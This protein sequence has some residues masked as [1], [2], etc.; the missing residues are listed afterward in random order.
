MNPLCHRRARTT[1]E[2][3]PNYDA[4]CFHAQQ[5]AEKYLKAILQEQSL[6]FGRSHNLIALLE[7]LLA[8]DREWENARAHLEVL[9]VYAV[10]IRYPGESADKAAARQAMQQVKAIRSRARRSLSLPA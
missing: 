10:T 8:H 7:L 4:A 5:C 9:S 2:E 6:P 1:S 3:D